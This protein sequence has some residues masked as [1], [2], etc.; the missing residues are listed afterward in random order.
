MASHRLFKMNILINDYLPNPPEGSLPLPSQGN[1]YHN[2]LAILNYSPEYPP[3]GDL[4][5]QYHGLEGE[6]I[7]ATPIHWQATHNNAAILAY[8]RELEWSAEESQKGLAVWNEF[9][10]PEHMQAYFHSPDTWLLKVDG[11][12][13][14]NAKPVHTLL[15]QPLLPE[16]EVLDTSLF[17]Q[18]FI[19]E[20]QM[21]FNTQT[22]HRDSTE[23]P[24]N[25]LWFW[26]NGTL[27]HRVEKRIAVNQAHLRALAEVVSTQVRLWA[28]T[29]NLLEDDIFLCDGVY[30]DDLLLAQQDLK[31]K[32]V[33]WYW[34]DTAYQ[35]HP[36]SWLSRLWRS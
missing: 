9:L 27:G 18:R 23:L 19:T 3:V 10:L 35:T 29:E 1:F 24:V 30:Q 13:K 31:N 22:L 7:I 34:N 16:L 33:Q 32:K 28:P 20:C 36:K 17:W 21:F 25:G 5:R 15:Q 12:P 8:G 6:W 2:L 11:K 26:G 14:L 4:L